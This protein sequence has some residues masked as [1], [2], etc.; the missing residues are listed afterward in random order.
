MKVF[1]GCDWT[2]FP[3]GW[4]WDLRLQQQTQPT[5][6]HLPLFSTT[7]KR[8]AWTASERFLNTRQKYCQYQFGKE[9]AASYKEMVQYFRLTA[10]QSAIA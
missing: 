7:D 9:L 8:A 5:E 2:E 3:P 1:C 10:T 4:P 6:T